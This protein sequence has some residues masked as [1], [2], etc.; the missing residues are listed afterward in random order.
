MNLRTA[1]TISQKQT[2]NFSGFV[3]QRVM[4]IEP[5]LPAW[6]AD[7]LPLNHTR[8]KYIYFYNYSKTL[9]KC[10]GIF[11]TI[12]LSS[13]AVN[14]KSIGGQLEVN[15]KSIGSQLEDAAD[16]RGR[17]SLQLQTRFFR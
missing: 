10:P 9:K 1:V 6:E 16:D 14:W 7:V 15:W 2:P 4:G 12:L 13:I 3:L 8:T 17:S 11:K 5:T